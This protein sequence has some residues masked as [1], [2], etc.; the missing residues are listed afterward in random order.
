MTYVMALRAL[1]SS[2]QQDDDRVSLWQKVNAI[3][4]TKMD[5]QRMD[6]VAHRCG[7]AS[8]SSGQAKQA[9]R[10]QSLRA[11][12]TQLGHPPVKRLGLDDLYHATIVVYTLQPILIEIACP[13]KGDVT[14]ILSDGR[15]GSHVSGLIK[16]KAW[17]ASISAA[18][19]ASRFWI[20]FCV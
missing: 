7:V 12:V 15:M 1:I 17:P 10:D 8:H 6:T 11:M 13:G 9:R 3:S 16:C 18:L 19:E 2:A 5:T 14:S 4:R 20:E